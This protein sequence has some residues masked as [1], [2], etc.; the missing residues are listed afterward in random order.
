[1]VVILLSAIRARMYT[2][3]FGGCPAIRPLGVGDVL[4]RE[5]GDGSAHEQGAAEGAHVPDG[6][7]RHVVGRRR[8]LG[9]GR[10]VAH[11]HAD[12]RAAVEVGLAVAGVDDV[13]DEN[14]PEAAA[15]TEPRLALVKQAGRKYIENG[16]I[17]AALL[18]EI[19]T[20]MIPEE[21][22]AAIVNGG[23]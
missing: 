9:I 23:I 10:G 7:V 5:A 20:P 2:P 8:E 17:D 14:A 11:V 18:T 1:M 3:Q 16:E 15:V 19:G 12:H 4:G 21:Q 13:L 22:Y 6:D